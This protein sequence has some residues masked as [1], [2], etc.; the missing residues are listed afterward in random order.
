[1]GHIVSLVNDIRR[2]YL[3]AAAQRSLFIELPAEDTEA[4]P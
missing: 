4:K 3:H 2:A 1:M